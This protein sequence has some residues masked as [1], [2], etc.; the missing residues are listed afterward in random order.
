MK[1]SLDQPSSSSDIIP[2]SVVRDMFGN[3]LDRGS[4][5][6]VPRYN[7]NKY[8]TLAVMV[9]ED[10]QIGSISGHPQEVLIGR[11]IHPTMLSKKMR[12][13]RPHQCV[14]VSMGKIIRE[15]PRWKDAVEEVVFAETE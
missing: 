3:P 5:V 4:I 9:V 1:R 15:D 14:E 12:Y 11:S 6:I 13:S 2:N 7:E 8:A 10:I